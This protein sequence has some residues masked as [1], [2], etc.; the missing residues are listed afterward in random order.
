MKLLFQPTC[1]HGDCQEPREGRVERVY[2][3]SRTVSY[4]CRPHAGDMRG[5]WFMKVSSLKR[6]A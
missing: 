2:Y 5:A 6:A 1:D 3:G 4:E